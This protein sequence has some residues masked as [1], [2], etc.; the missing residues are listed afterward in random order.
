M[1]QNIYSATTIKEKR[2]INNLQITW[3][4]VKIFILWNLWKV[5]REDS[6]SQQ[7]LFEFGLINSFW[8]IILKRVA[9]LGS[10]W[11][12]AFLDNILILQNMFLVVLVLEKHFAFLSK[13]KNSQILI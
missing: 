9:C 10:F 12:N 7:M 1:F 8:R 5:V 6:Q 13:H 2:I 3:T 11:E 4:K